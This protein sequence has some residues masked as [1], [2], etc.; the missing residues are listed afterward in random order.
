[1]DRDDRIGGV[2]L[3]AEHLLG[4]G[5]IDL[6]FE[7]I[8]CAFEIGPDILTA[9]RPFEQHAKV[10]DLGGKAVAQLEILREAA[11]PLEGFLCLGLV[12]PETG[13]ADLLFELG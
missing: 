6:R 9:A 1:V 10:V 3:A 13:S 2:V 12:V 5:G 4:F 7:R 8:E 11:L